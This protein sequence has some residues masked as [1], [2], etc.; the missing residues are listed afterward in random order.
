[1]K[2][3]TSIFLLL[4]SGVLSFAQYQVK[5]E[6]EAKSMDFTN[7]TSKVFKDNPKEIVIT[8]FK[9][10]YRMFKGEAV[11]G[12]SYSPTL[13]TSYA[14]SATMNVIMQGMTKEAILKTTDEIYRDFVSGLEGKGYKVSVLDP[15]KVK[16]SKKFTKDGDA[17]I[18][19]GYTYEYSHKSMLQALTAIP[20]GVNAV[21]MKAPE[22][23]AAAGRG[24]SGGAVSDIKKGAIINEVLQG[25]EVLRLTVNLVIDFC[26]FTKKGKQLSGAPLLHIGGE[27]ASSSGITFVNKKMIFG[28][29]NSFSNK[30]MFIEE[31]DWAGDMKETTNFAF[32][33]SKLKNFE[34]PVDEGKY[35]RAAKT[36]VKAYLDKYISSY[37]SFVSDLNK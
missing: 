31:T 26:D 30:P 2:T 21:E 16:T 12:S 14:T 7:S 3:A 5:Y 17:Q 4:F 1:M 8:D 34:M 20:T 10:T 36:L 6:N 28:T 25:Q 24:G 22:K 37:E 33:G 29:Y 9:I 32:L 13:N 27:Y 11:Q 15:E 18:L 35:T 19:N 23:S